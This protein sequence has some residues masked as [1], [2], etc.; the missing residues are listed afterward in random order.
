MT[1]FTFGFMNTKVKFK[2]DPKFIHID[3]TL[4]C[5]TYI[6]MHHLDIWI[7][8]CQNNTNNGTGYA[9]M[10]DIDAGKVAHQLRAGG[11]VTFNHRVIT[12]G[13]RLKNR[14]SRNLRIEVRTSRDRSYPTIVGSDAGTATDKQCGTEC[15]DDQEERLFHSMSFHLPCGCNQDQYRIDPA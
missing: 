5:L 6:F 8:L 4:K 12:F 1:D 9:Q 7:S 3:E 2:D 10:P 11:H 15:S 13:N 14:I